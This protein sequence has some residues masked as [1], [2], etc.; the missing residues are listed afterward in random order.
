MA[1]PSALADKLEDVVA[2]LTLGLGVLAVVLG[3]DH[4]WAI[5]VV[6]W[7]LVVPLIDEVGADVI[8][9]L[10]RRTAD[11]SEEEF[12]PLATLQDRYARGELDEATFERRLERLLENETVEDV[13]RRLERETVDAEQ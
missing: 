6:G 4:A 2:I 8:G 3:V 13:E 7:L 10:A 5:F 11:R 1:D 12:N 9:W